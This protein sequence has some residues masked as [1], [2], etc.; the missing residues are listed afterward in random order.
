MPNIILVD[1]AQVSS[2]HFTSIQAAINAAN[3]GDIVQVAAGVYNEE[4]IIDK[5]LTLLGAGYNTN[6]EEGGRSDGESIIISNYPITITASNVKINGFELSGFSAGINIPSFAFEMMFNNTIKN[7]VIEYNWI[8]TVRGTVGVMAEAG[9]L[10]RLFIRNNI[11]SV[12]ND[13]SPTFAVINLGRGGIC[14]TIYQNIEITNNVLKN[15]DI[16]YS[17][18]ANANPIDYL[19]D[20]LSILYNHFISPAGGFATKVGNVLNGQFNFNV[21][22]AGISILGIDEGMILGNSF[23]YGAY[24]SLLGT[25]DGFSRP[26][27]KVTILSNDFTDEVH[28]MGLVLLEGVVSNTLFVQQNAFRN[29]GIV[30]CLIQNSGVG[31]LVADYNWWDSIDGPSGN[32]GELCGDISV[33]KWITEFEFGTNHFVSP[34]W[35]LSTFL[36]RLPGFWP[37][38]VIGLRYIGGN[39]FVG[40]E[41]IPLLAQVSYAGG[42]VAT[43]VTFE[44]DQ[45][46]YVA[47]AIEDGAAAV[48]AHDVLP[49]THL[50]TVS[51]A[52]FSNSLFITVVP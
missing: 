35:P 32:T 27:R 24:L 25:E 1:I 43:P 29:S 2:A 44:L 16:S 15:G 36:T 34:P 46:T 13:G 4:V 33:T 11:I 41:C 12:Y 21:V 39:F 18:N 14:K 52:G 31:T 49:G 30:G 40:G 20:N 6:P 22:D 28:G 26:S 3:P 42:F 45:H 47:T 8:H 9:V 5:P 50:L 19:I 7:I 38:F 17:I 37:K 51:T 48:C 23:R 10:D